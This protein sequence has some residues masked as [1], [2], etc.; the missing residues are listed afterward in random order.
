MFSSSLTTLYFHFILDP[1]FSMLVG[2]IWQ[3]CFPI[4][5]EVFKLVISNLLDINYHVYRSHL[6]SE[7]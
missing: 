3:I 7:P 2:I 4:V 6:L 5:M 1:T